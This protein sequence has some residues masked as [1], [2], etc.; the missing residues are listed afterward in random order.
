MPDSRT[1][2]QRQWSKLEKRE[3][4]GD[5][6]VRIGCYDCGYNQH[7]AALDLDHLPGFEKKATVSQLVE[8]DYSLSVIFAEIEKCEVVCS[9]CH[10]IRT[11]M[12]RKESRRQI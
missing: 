1:L 2:E 10:R 9:N 11:S 6:K 7:P 5:Y 12:R 8:G 3:L 4:V